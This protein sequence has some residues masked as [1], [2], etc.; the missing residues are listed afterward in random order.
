[1]AVYL[2]MAMTLIFKPTGI[3]GRAGGAE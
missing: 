1:M 2:L 3:F